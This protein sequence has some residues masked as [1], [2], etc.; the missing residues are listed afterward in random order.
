[1]KRIGSLAVLVVFGFSFSG[2]K[3]DTPDTHESVTGEMLD[4]TKEF[5]SEL[6]GVKT[7]DDL[8]KAAGGLKKL[9]QRMQVIK[10]KMDKLES[11]APASEEE[12]MKIMGKFPE[13]IPQSMTLMEN[14]KRLSQLAASDPEAAKIMAELKPSR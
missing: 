14:M 6:E 12:M 11:G 4:V 3:G 2:C 13:L 10:E 7:A 9:A 5:N 8:K 1:M